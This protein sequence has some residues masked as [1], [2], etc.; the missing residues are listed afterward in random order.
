M[1]LPCCTI[2]GEYFQPFRLEGTDAERWMSE[3]GPGLKRIE[4]LVPQANRPAAMQEIESGLMTVEGVTAA[5]VNLTGRRVAVTF[6]VQAL[7]PQALIDRLGELGY[8][9]RPFD[10]RETGLT[11]DDREGARLLKALAISGFAASN[12]M[13]LSV[14]VWSGAED[15]TR[16]LFHWLSAMIALPAVAYAGRPFFYSAINALRLGRVNMDVPISL[17]VG[18]ATALLRRK[19]GRMSHLRFKEVVHD[20]ALLL[21]PASV[22]AWAQRVLT[23][24]A[25]LDVAA[26]VRDWQGTTVLCTAAPQPYAVAFGMLLDM[27][28]VQGSTRTGGAFVE[29]VSTEKAA[30]LRAGLPAG[31]ECAITDD[32]L[33]DAPLLALAHRPLVVDRSG[34]IGGVARGETGA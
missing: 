15:A 9:A 19:L 23:R 20:A 1:T 22:S 4:F 31:V 24:H 3:A 33:I 25:H 2:D 29:N 30:R 16:D 34:R 28:V 32:P 21:P 7:E 14:S 13:L 27:D 6:K 17:G 26:L 5:R 12:V 11:R 10:P 18:L 8:M